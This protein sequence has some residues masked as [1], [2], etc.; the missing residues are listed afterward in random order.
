MGTMCV[1]IAHGFLPCSRRVLIGHGQHPLDEGG[2]G[3]GIWACSSAVIGRTRP[4]AS[5]QGTRRGEDGGHD[6]PGRFRRTVL[7]PVSSSSISI[8]WLPSA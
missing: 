6:P 1:E 2:N 7:P 8:L 5:L 3:P 4:V